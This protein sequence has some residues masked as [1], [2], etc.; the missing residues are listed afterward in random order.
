M[1]DY[2][3]IKQD[4]CERCEGTG[5]YESGAWARYQQAIAEGRNHLL[6]ASEIFTWDGVPYPA[7]PEILQECSIRDCFECDGKGIFRSEV[8]LSEAL[9]AMGR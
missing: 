9:D 5:K 8:S 3:V 4:Q 7:P 1:S 6:A 2:R